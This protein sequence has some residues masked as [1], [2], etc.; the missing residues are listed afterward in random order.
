MVE[1]AVE[2]P[3]VARRPI[4][5][6]IAGADLL[7]NGRFD[8]WKSAMTTIQDLDRAAVQ[9]IVDAT[10]SHAPRAEEAPDLLSFESKKVRR[11]KKGTY[12][13]EGTLEADGRRGSLDVVVEVPPSHSA[14]FAVS[15][16]AEREAFG[17]SWADLVDVGGAALEGEANQAPMNAQAW[18]RVPV[19]AAA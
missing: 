18:L 1:P 5:L 17:D 10:S 6:R 16:I 3:R 2:T 14:F 13:V 8:N 19:L 11:T 7:L 9:L 4:R 12:Q 15:F